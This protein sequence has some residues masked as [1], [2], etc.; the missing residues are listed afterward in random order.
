MG[1]PHFQNKEEEG[2]ECESNVNATVLAQVIIR[3]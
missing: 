3:E 1:H 2:R